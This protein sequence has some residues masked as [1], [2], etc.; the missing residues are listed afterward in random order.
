[1]MRNL[2]GMMK[3]MHETQSQLAKLKS[4][5]ESQYFSAGAGNDRVKITV[6]GSGA[7][8]S[9]NIDPSIIDPKDVELLEDMICQA[10]TKA[11]AAASAEKAR[12]VKDITGDFKL[13]PGVSLP[14]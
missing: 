13:P 12:L 10:T 8:H 9:V 3:K 14:F 7:L 6:T 1:M 5:L 4:D 2:A 11:Q